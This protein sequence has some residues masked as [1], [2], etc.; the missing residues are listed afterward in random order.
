MPDRISDILSML[1]KDPTDVFLHYSLGMEYAS[2]GRYDQAVAQFNRCIELDAG[3]LAAYSEAGKALRSADLLDEAREMFAA[4]MKLAAM[5]GQTHVR[6]F[7]RQQLDS[8]P[9]P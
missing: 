1:E 8:L 3:Y 5:Q 6:D 2:V 7:I 4:G 9:G